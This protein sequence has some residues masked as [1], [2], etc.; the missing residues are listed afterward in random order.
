[1]LFICSEARLEECPAL[2][3]LFP[4]SSARVGSI[5]SLADT[6][7]ADDTHHSFPSPQ[8]YDVGV[9]DAI[10][11]KYAHNALELKRIA[12]TCARST[13][14]M[15]TMVAIEGLSDCMDPSGSL[16][17]ANSSCFLR[18]YKTCLALFRSA[19]LDIER[20]AGTV[21]SFVVCDESLSLIARDTRADLLQALCPGR[22]ELNAPRDHQQQQQAHEVHE[23]LTLP[24]GTAHLL[25]AVSLVATTTPRGTTLI[26]DVSV[27]G[28][29]R[30]SS[31][32]SSSSSSVL[33]LV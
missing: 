3:V 4:S 18:D 32:S 20:E 24:L 28:Q 12:L 33:V 11:I 1:M 26:A 15:Y 22:L 27:Y 30:S 7:C 31:S 29:L 16:I 9:L 19:L 6:H 10:D 5:G 8:H 14:G 23:T 13:A 2:S 25:D 17:R 21:T